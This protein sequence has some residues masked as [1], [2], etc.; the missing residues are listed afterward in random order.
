[1]S[2][3]ISGLGAKQRSDFIQSFLDMNGE[4]LGNGISIE[5]ETPEYKPNKLRQ[6]WNGHKDGISIDVSVING[7]EKHKLHSI[8][9]WDD[10]F[11]TGIKIGAQH[12]RRIMQG[13]FPY[14]EKGL[15]AEDVDLTL[16]VVREDCLE[17]SQR[18]YQ[19]DMP[20]MPEV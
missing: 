3:E 19:R 4:N 13:P 8:K 6:W 1:M 14:R 10:G 12:W 20:L 11:D 18:L 9:V 7:E 17:A 2:N 15:I 5:V 16:E